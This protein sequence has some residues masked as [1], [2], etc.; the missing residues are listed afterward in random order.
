MGAVGTLP[1]IKSKYEYICKPDGQVCN[2]NYPITMNNA[3][4]LLFSGVLEMA[5]VL[6]PFMQGFEVGGL[7]G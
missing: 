4:H 5:V 6:L 7:R 3:T 1:G 2:K